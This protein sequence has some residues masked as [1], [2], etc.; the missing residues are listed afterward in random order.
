MKFQFQFRLVK[1]RCVWSILL[2]LSSRSLGARPPATPST[3]ATLAADHRSVSLLLLGAPEEARRVMLPHVHVSVQIFASPR[4]NASAAS[5]HVHVLHLHQLQSICNCAA[6]CQCLNIDP[7]TLRRNSFKRLRFQYSLINGFAHSRMRL[8]SIPH[9]RRCPQNW[10][11]KSRVTRPL[12][13]TASML[14]TCISPPRGY[15]C[16]HVTNVNRRIRNITHPSNYDH[17]ARQQAE[18]APLPQRS[19]GRLDC[20]PGRGC[21]PVLQEPRPGAD[22]P[23]SSE[24]RLHGLIQTCGGARRAG[25]FQRS[26]ATPPR[27]CAAACSPSAR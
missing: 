5:M 16:S 23:S 10:F 21:V 14:G 13:W 11:K 20:P 1:I 4:S 15:N 19:G 17:T 27:T 3:S 8:G 2:L 26:R 22:A 18:R 24:P 25:S 6:C 7:D 9:R 12:R